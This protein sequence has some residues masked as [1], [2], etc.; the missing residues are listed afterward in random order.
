MLLAIAF[1]LT[2]PILPVQALWINLVTT[3]ALALP[4]ALEALE[5]DAM[6]RPPRRPD[7]PLLGRAALERIAL[8]ALFMF[9][10]GIGIFEWEEARGASEEEARTAVIATIVLIEAFY[11]LNCRSLRRSLRSVGVFSNPS[12]YGGIALVVGLQAAFTHLAFMN[13]LFGSA[14]LGPAEWG[15]AA[16]VAT[17]VLPVVALEKRIRRSRSRRGSGRS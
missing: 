6:R 12:V 9:A 15:R 2:L 10:A 5:P 1:G 3:V 17:L 4:L 8:V 13:S 14:P 7:A 16:L 11:L